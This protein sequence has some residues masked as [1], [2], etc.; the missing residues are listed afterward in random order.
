MDAFGLMKR[1]GSISKSKNGIGAQRL[2][3]NQVNQR[4]T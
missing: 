1:E 4:Y 3:F 2:I